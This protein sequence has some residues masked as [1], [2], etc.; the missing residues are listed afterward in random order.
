MNC[1]TCRCPAR[2]DYWTVGEDGNVEESDWKFY[3]VVWSGYKD[4]DIEHKD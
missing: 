1:D 2:A 3:G 4:D